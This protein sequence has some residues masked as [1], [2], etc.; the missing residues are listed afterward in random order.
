[1]SGNNVLDRSAMATLARLENELPHIGQALASLNEGQKEIRDSQMAM[2]RG[3]SRIE[4]DL[5]VANNKCDRNA[6]DIEGHAGR[7]NGLENDVSGLKSTDKV[8]GGLNA[9]YATIAAL[10]AGLL[11]GGGP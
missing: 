3:M 4:S 5:A 6:K 1:M 8:V 10:L 2:T 9:V 11:G 7:L